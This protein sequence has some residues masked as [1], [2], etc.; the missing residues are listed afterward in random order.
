MADTKDNVKNDKFLAGK[1]IRCKRLMFNVHIKYQITHSK[2]NNT[3]CAFLNLSSDHWTM[4]SD[5]EYTNSTN[6]YSNTKQCLAQQLISQPLNIG[7]QVCS[8]PAQILIWK[9]CASYVKWALHLSKK[10][11]E[12]YRQRWILKTLRWF[13]RTYTQR[14]C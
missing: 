7:F 4:F 13:I 3:L 8:A 6:H 2:I 5:L 11:P 10:L 12:L 9:Q 1:L 14:M